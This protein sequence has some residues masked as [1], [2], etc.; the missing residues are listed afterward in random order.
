MLVNDLDVSL[1]GDS[2]SRSDDKILFTITLLLRKT[3]FSQRMKI[4][5][6]WWKTTSILFMPQGTQ[7]HPK[8]VLLGI[9]AQLL[10]TS[11]KNIPAVPQ[12]HEVTDNHTPVRVTMKDHTVRACRGG[13]DIN[14]LLG[15][16]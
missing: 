7:S 5:Y 14:H 16:L 15:F 1:L 4:S 2:D 10:L 3:I 12:N 13:I 8:P 11:T 9:C 6:F